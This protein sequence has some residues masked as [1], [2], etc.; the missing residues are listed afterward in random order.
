MNI[1]LQMQNN[2]LNVLKLLLINNKICGVSH[3]CVTLPWTYFRVCFDLGAIQV[4]IYFHNY[5]SNEK[6]MNKIDKLTL[7]CIVL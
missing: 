2:T 3:L 5:K 6:P 1:F 7:S 4:D